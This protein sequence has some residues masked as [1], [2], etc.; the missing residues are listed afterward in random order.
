MMKLW[1]ILPLQ[2]VLL[3]APTQ[4][5]H[6]E[7]SAAQGQVTLKGMKL[8]TIFWEGEYVGNVR[9]RTQDA[10]LLRAE[11]RF[12]PIS[13]RVEARDPIASGRLAAL[14]GCG[15]SGPALRVLPLP[16]GQAHRAGTAGDARTVDHLS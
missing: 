12:G 13:G 6:L 15:W 9:A 10:A 11:E 3:A 7:T 16:A 1:T 8:W 2:C 5:A 14:R 4:C